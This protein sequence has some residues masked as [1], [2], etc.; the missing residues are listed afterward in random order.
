LVVIIYV[1]NLTAPPFIFSTAILLGVHHPSSS[2][3]TA[4]QPRG[5]L[6]KSET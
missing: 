3:L 2:E 1:K 5:R 4:F 6:K